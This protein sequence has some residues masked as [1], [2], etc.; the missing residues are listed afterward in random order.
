MAFSAPRTW[1]AGELVT[2]VLMN[3]HVRDNYSALDARRGLVGWPI[4]ARVA[5][6]YNFG[7][8]ATA[9]T[10]T[11]NEMRLVPVS[12][13]RGVTLERIGITV[14]TGAASSE[15][16][17]GVYDDTGEVHPR[18]RLA[19][20]TVDTSTAGDKEATISVGVESGSVIWLAGVRQGSGSPAIYN[21]DTIVPYQLGDT[22]LPDP[23]TSNAH[24]VRAGITGGMPATMTGQSLTVPTG[25]SPPRIFVRVS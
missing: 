7:R 15:V 6:Y 25:A 13:P 14:G 2:A 10:W 5:G 17:L 18:N 8:G 16:R 12:V 22:A 21:A 24:L 1:V 4:G 20:E 9:A 19:M 11:A 23:T 3:A